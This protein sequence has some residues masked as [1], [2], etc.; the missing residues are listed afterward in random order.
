MPGRLEEGDLEEGDCE[1]I[2]G[3]QLYSYKPHYPTSPS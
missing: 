1:Q 3:S 2:T